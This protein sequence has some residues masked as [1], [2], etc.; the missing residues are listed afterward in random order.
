[1][2]F[3][4]DI[5]PLFRQEDRDA[6]I[7]QPPL[8]MDLWSYNDVYTYANEILQAVQ[9]GTMPCDGPWTPDKVATFQAWINAGRPEVDPVPQ[10]SFIITNRDTFSTDAVNV[11]GIPAVFGNAFYVVYDGFAAKDFGATSADPRPGIPPTLPGFVFANAGAGNMQQVNPSASYE[12]PSTDIGIPQRITIAYGLQF[13]NTND[14]PTTLGQAKT[15]TMQVSLATVTANAVLTLV[16]QANPYMVDVDAAQQNPYWLSFDTRV[17]QVT[18]GDTKLSVPQGADPFAFLQSAMANLRADP[19]RFEN[20]LS[21]DENVSVLELSQQVGGKNVFNYAIAR[22]RYVAPA[23]TP[24]TNVQL[25]FRV[26]STLVSALD[27]DSTSGS[28]GNYRRTGNTSGPS[29]VGSMPVLGIQRDQAGNGEIASF[30]CFAEPRVNDMSMQTDGNNN[31]TINGGGISEQVEFFGCWLD[32][33]QTTPLFPRD[34]LADTGGPNGPFTGNGGGSLQSIQTLINGIHQC[35][36]AEIFFWPSGTVSDPI[37]FQASPASSDRLAQRNLSI[38]PSGN[39][40]WP[41]AHTIQH[42]FTVKPSFSPLGQLFGTRVGLVGAKPKVTQ[43]GNRAPDV[44][45]RAV[46]QPLQRPDELILHW[47]N[48]PRDST[49]TIYLPEVEADEILALSALRPHP[50]VLSKL[51]EHT[52]SCRLA[53]VTFLPLPSGRHGTLAGLLSLTLP[54]KLRIGQA[55]RFSVEQYS[56]YSLKTLGAFQITTPVL[57]DAQ[58]L[59]NELRKYSV[60]RYIQQTIPTGNRW[61]SIFQR[62][63]SQIAGRIRALGGDPNA[64][65]PS[66]D[67][68][69]GAVEACPPHKGRPVCPPDLFCFNIPWNEC[70]IEG[71]IELKVRFKRKCKE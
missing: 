3:T 36:V 61:Y 62:Y 49:A 39:P 5:K 16:K 27:Y 30:P 56:G 15:V 13:N 66:P 51:D 65:K 46:A 54:P 60:L 43:H 70:D 50:Q 68:G 1:M 33:N 40:G 47:N 53:D 35:L 21:A 42:T 19:A 12:D 38:N 58:I 31:R 7:N 20:E 67:G 4:N 6:M 64:V 17:F 59:P 71:E 63:L 23:Q 37:Q 48:V 57:R 18:E 14:F 44:T 55:F 29:G 52:L 45:A 28:T 10:S 34:P 8:P 11:L 2:N 25:F 32:I 41:D 9:N 26:F 69:E 22:V 24:A